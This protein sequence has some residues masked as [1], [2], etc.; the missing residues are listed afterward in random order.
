VEGW[1]VSERV[2]S[3]LEASVKGGRDSFI[4]GE[5]RKIKVVNWI[6]SRHDG[7]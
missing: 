5:V 2:V 1:S 3:I 4:E 6:C 7:G